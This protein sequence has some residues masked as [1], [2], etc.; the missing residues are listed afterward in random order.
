MEDKVRR[1]THQKIKT[2]AAFNKITP[3]I[4]VKSKT[5]DLVVNASKR[6]ARETQ[7]ML[8][9]KTHLEKVESTI[10]KIKMATLCSTAK[11]IF[12]R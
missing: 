2:V 11:Q 4:Q 3:K 7:S 1:G 10:K 6:Y 12:P 5:A 9:L 8:K